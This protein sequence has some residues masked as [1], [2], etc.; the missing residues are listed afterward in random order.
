[1]DSFIVIHNPDNNPL[2]KLEDFIKKFTSIHPQIPCSFT[3][4]EDFA[5]AAA[6]GN[7]IY[8]VSWKVDLGGMKE[9]LLGYK[10]VCTIIERGSKSYGHHFRWKFKNTV[11]ELEKTYRGC[12]FEC[13]IKINSPVVTNWFDFYDDNAMKGIP[14][15][16]ANELDE[17]FKTNNFKEFI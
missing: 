1:M 13:P 5:K 12:Y 15:N 2:G 14:L 4:S 11:E 7:V 17:I 8:V 3:N 10:F 9:Y 6:K 16:I